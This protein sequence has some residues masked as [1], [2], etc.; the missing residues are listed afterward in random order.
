MIILRI[1]LRRKSCLR[2]FFF[3]STES[4]AENRAVLKEIPQKTPKTA[5]KP[6]R[7]KGGK[8]ARGG[9]GRHWRQNDFFDF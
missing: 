8:K 3:C 2:L 9:R 7:A 6:P 5:K 4:I 1:F